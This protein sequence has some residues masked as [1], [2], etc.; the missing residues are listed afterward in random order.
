MRH[1][2]IAIQ[3]FIEMVTRLLT[4]SL[5]GIGVIAVAALLIWAVM[6]LDR[7]A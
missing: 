5:M 4:F 6:W 7:N 2:D 1:L 3:G